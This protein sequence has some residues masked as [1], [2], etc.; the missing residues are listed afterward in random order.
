M[1][2]FVVFDR[3]TGL[4][5]TVQQ[6]P[7]LP[8]DEL[9]RHYRAVRNSDFGRVFEDSTLEYVYDPLQAGTDKIVTRIRLPG[10]DS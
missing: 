4:I 7:V 1:I 3:L 6:S 2:T 5:E 9:L 8:D 10:G